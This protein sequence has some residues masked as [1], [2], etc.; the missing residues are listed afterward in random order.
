MAEW[1]YEAG[2]GE[3][4]AA[5]IEDRRIVEAMIEVED[6]GL[7]AGTIADARLTE[8]LIA[9]RRGVATLGSHEALVEPLP[10]ASTLGG[11]VRIEVV[12]EAIAEP[13]RAKRA[14]AR[15]SEAAVATGPSLRARIA[16]SGIAVRDIGPRDPDLLEEAGWTEVLDAAATGDWAFEG[17]S[18]KIEPTAAMTVI[19]VDGYLPASA[20]ALAAASASAAAIRALG[21]AGSIGID[22]PTVDNRAARLDVAD[23]FDAALP[24]PFERTA[25]N[26]FGFMQVIRPRVRASLIEQ[27]R[28]DPAGQALRALLRRVERSGHVGAARL[29]LHPRV[30]A[31]A[32]ANPEWIDRLARQFGGA[33]ALRSDATLAMSAGYVEAF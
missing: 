6:S 8:V 1:L 21:I 12:R 23:A 28:H 15:P 5:L 33:V 20:L 2:I 17:G 22:F 26:G 14:K 24:L 7:R 27:M 13:G 11:I 16:A 19:D 3:A 10:K 25:I 30:A 4:R 9:G 31:V 29:V 18:L 32:Q